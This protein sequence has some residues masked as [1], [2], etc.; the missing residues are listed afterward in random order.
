MNQKG[1]CGMKNFIEVELFSRRGAENFVFSFEMESHRM[2][3]KYLELVL[4]F[5]S[6]LAKIDQTN[7]YW[8]FHLSE[9]SLLELTNE[10]QTRV[11]S[12]QPEPEIPMKYKVSPFITQ[13]ELN[14]IHGDFERYLTLINQ[15]KILPKNGK[16]AIE[17]LLQINL[18]IHK[19]ENHHRLRKSVEA[20]QRESIS[21]NFGFRFEGDQFFNLEDE[22]YDCFTSDSV[23]GDIFCGYNTTGKSFVHCY[24]DGD[25]ELVRSG[26]VRPQRTF[27]TE[28][29]VHF[30]PNG[31]GAELMEKMK[32]WWRTHR[33]DESG[34]RFDDRKNAFGLIRI[35]RLIQTKEFRGKTHW[36]K[37][38]FLSQFDGVADCRIVD[39]PS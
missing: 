21:C 8:N 24:Y 12:L 34:Y 25:T 19:I 10:L 2:A 22:D 17:D 23:F 36:E 35:G 13:E 32:D 6:R 1:H 31:S 38:V 30:G 3:R 26:G 28:G 7:S 18:L 33:I 20:G 9:D 16:Q 14:C 4:A 37:L 29:F 27:S 5:K 11:D 15:K 39:R